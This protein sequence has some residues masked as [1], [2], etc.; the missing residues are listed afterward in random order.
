MFELGQIEVASKD[1]HKQRWIT[2][3]FMINVKKVVVSDKEP[4]NN[5]NDWRHIEAVK[6]MRKQ[7]YHCLSRCLKIYLAMAYHIM[8]GTLPTQW[9]L[10]F[11]RQQNGCFSI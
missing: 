10:M 8:K 1:F 3:I 6:Y 7:L 2:D 11:L 5:G 4:C 9:H